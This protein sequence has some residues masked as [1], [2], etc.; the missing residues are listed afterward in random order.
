MSDKLDLLR[1]EEKL[2]RELG[3]KEQ[4]AYVLGAQAVLLAQSGQV[5]SAMDK[6]DEAERLFREIEHQ[7]GVEKILWSEVN[8]LRE[9]GS[10]NL[11]DALQRQ[12]AFYRSTGEEEELAQCLFDQVV[13]FH[14]QE[15]LSRE[16]EVLEKQ[17]PL[18]EHLGKS[19]RL[20]AC[21][22]MAAMCLVELNVDLEKALKFVTE[23]EH[24][25]RKTNDQQ[26]LAAVAGT[27]MVVTAACEAHGQSAR[28]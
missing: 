6:F 10:P 3:N 20:V 15:N 13:A 4:L 18:W 16:E 8:I 21:Y 2:H 5:P 11:I 17:M 19:D 1:Q 14:D 28:P 25:C 12:E 24:I 9:C 26:R 7:V 23:V 22:C 27:K